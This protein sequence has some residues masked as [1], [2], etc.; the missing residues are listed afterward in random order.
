[1]SN[2]KDSLI[3]NNKV[4]IIEDDI[5]LLDSELLH[6]LLLDRT[7]GKNIIWATD[8][9][10]SYGRGFGKTDEIK[11]FLITNK[12][13]M[14]IQP[15]ITKE[16]NNQ[17]E[18]TKERAEVFTPSWVCNKQNN[19]VDEQWFGRRDVFNVET[20]EGWK[21]TKN[22]IVFPDCEGKSWQDYVKANRLEI[23]CGEAPYLV[24]RYDSVTGKIIKV[25]DRIGLLDRK[26][27][28]ISENVDEK[29]AWIGWAYT[30]FKSVYGFEFQGDNLLL[31]RENLLFT[32][33]DHYNFKF[34][35]DIEPKVLEDIAEI[36]SWNIWQMDGINYAIPFDVIRDEVDQISIFD[37][38]G[39]ETEKKTRFAKTKNWKNGR[40]IEFRNI[41]SRR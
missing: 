3:K 11:S 13:R 2:K 28:I 8:D 1:M 36:I 12:Y 27:R 35:S 9:Y 25:G 4:D 19:L 24:S 41:Y 30:A 38:I 29:D 15:R 21:T 10:A 26:L 14:I 20:F 40:P 6:I 16:L 22:K 34:S 17:V 5:E 33:I 31:A 18:R 39:D 32:F 23:T 37:I 7:T